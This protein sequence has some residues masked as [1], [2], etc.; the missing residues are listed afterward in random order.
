MLFLAQM[1]TAPQLPP[2]PEGP[3][4]D[5]VRGPIE[6]P[7]YEPWQMALAIGCVVLFLGLLIGL[8]LR[9]RRKAAPTTP[10]YEAAIAEL[11]AAAQLTDDDD[12]RF[13][14]LSSQA[15]R[16]Y[17]EDGLG[18]RSTVRTSEEFL[19]SL[20]G[21]SVTSGANSTSQSVAERGTRLSPNG[22]FDRIEEP[23]PQLESASRVRYNST[24]NFPQAKGNTHFDETFQSE[25]REVLTVFD[26]IKFAQQAISQEKRTHLTDTVRS[27]I[28]QAHATTQKEGARG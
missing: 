14:V 4:I 18:L 20:E 9:A 13:A 26:Q 17:L 6:I 5:R 10:P 7:A 19:R 8:F 21:K 27:L 23:V 11:D 3:A 22:E 24:D 1:P 12:E 2:L 25:L 15:L 16:R 28:N